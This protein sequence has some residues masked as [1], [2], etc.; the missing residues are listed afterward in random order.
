[1]LKNTKISAKNGLFRTYSTLGTFEQKNC[2]CY[3]ILISVDEIMEK[4]TKMKR[5]ESKLKVTDTKTIAT[6]SEYE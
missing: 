3:L 2:E 6:L 4:Y 1:M 5:F